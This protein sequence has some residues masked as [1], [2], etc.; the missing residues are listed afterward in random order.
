MKY[1][2]R[3]ITKNLSYCRNNLRFNLKYT[4]KTFVFYFL[5]FL[6]F[7]YFFIFLRLTFVMIRFIDLKMAPV[8]LEW[9]SKRIN[10]DTL[11]HLSVKFK[12]PIS[13]LHTPHP[14][15]INHNGDKTTYF[16]VGDSTDL[17][18]QCLNESLLKVPWMHI[19]RRSKGQCWP[20]FPVLFHLSTQ[21]EK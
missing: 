8:V 17:L 15:L 7:Y 4:L 13:L 11:L 9:K 16:R 6:F 12:V 20:F 5:H 21:T 1:Q 2:F 3:P 10:N 19:G 14:S 18:Y